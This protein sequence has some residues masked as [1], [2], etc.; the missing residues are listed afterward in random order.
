MNDTDLAHI[1]DQIAPWLAGAGILY[2]IFAIITLIIVVSI[3]ISV[4]RS[5]KKMRDDFDKEWRRPFR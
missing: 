5:M 3:F 4:F 1:W 2:A